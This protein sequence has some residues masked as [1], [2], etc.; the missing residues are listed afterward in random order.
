MGIHLPSDLH[1]EFEPF[2]PS[3]IDADVVLLAGDTHIKGRGV[4]WAVEAFSCPVLYIPRNHEHYSG[5]LF[6]TLKK[7]RSLASNSHVQVLD[8]D[9]VVADSTLTRTPIP[10]T[11]GQ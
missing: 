9:V 2:E 10:R 3:I 8:R 5:H 1:L 4:D 6:A 7:M 11:S